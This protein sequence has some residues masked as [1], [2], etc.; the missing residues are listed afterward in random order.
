MKQN[1][2]YVY[3]ETVKDI[4]E[5]AHS[6]LRKDIIKPQPERGFNLS[7]AYMLE[8]FVKHHKKD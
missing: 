3:G 7:F 2:V 4:Q 8:Q 6:A 5:W 1:R